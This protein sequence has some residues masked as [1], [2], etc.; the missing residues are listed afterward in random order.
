MEVDSG[1]VDD[2]KAPRTHLA[3]AVMDGKRAA[4]LHDKVAKL[5]KDLSFFEPE[6]LQ[7]HV[8][9]EPCRHR[10]GALSKAGLGHL[11]IEGL[12]GDGRAKEGM[13]ATGEIGD[14]LDPLAGP[15]RRQRQA[16]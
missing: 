10:T 14:R 8:T 7:C 15:G 12:G 11:V 6:Y 1:R 13:E 4:I 3:P 9:D 16:Q 2:C 5:S